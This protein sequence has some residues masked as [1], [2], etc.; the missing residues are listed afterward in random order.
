M[1]TSSSLSN[2]TKP[3]VVVIAKHLQTAKGFMDKLGVHNDEWR[4]VG[5]VEDIMGKHPDIVFVYDNDYAN[6]ELDPKLINYVMSYTW[7]KHIDYQ[8]LQGRVYDL[9]NRRWYQRLYRKI[10]K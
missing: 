5:R 9:E 10:F 2:I 7:R 1:K 6:L 4:Y 3:D 8:I